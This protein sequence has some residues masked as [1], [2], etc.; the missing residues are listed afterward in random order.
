MNN[1]MRIIL[2]LSLAL[3]SAVM[4]AS[5]YAATIIGQQHHGSTAERGKCRGADDTT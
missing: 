4:S 5:D 3:G 2:G 1:S